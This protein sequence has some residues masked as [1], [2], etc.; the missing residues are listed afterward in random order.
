MDTKTI[1]RG[2]FGAG[3]DSKSL[4]VADESGAV[5]LRGQNRGEK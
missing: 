1:N 4:T 2:G 5:L 3:H